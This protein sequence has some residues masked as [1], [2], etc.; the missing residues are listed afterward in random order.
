M[1]DFAAAPGQPNMYGLIQGEANT[2]QPGKR[3]LSAMTPSI[4]LDPAGTLFMVV[5]T[6]GGPTIITTVT[7]VISN[8]IDHGMDLATAVAAPRIHHQAL[9]DRIDYENGG[10]TPEVVAQLERMGHTVRERRGHSGEVAGIMRTGAGWIAV[11]DPR[12]GGW[13]VG[14]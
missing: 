11:A 6:P 8:V 10:L 7:Q 4:V 2:I 12:S 14:Y 5:G 9:P 3:M 1:D 13:S